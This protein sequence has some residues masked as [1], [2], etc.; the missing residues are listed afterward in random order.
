MNRDQ[1]LKQTN[2]RQFAGLLSERCHSMEQK[3]R[4]RHPICLFFDAGSYIAGDGLSSIYFQCFDYNQL[5]ILIQFLRDVGGL[6]LAS[7]LE[8]GLQIYYRGRT[9]LRTFEDC[10]HAG[11]TGQHISKEKW[12]ELDALEDGMLG[13]TGLFAQVEGQ[14][15][16][17]VKSNPALLD[18]LAAVE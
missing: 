15:L 3:P 9:D 6:E 10:R 14:L 13:P 12:A 18:G 17:F 16:G 2:P 8:A 11:F 4:S 7:R 5:L 1:L